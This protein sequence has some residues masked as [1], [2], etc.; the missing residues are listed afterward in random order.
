MYWVVWPGDEG[1]FIE[2]EEAGRLWPEIVIDFLEKNLK[3]EDS[4]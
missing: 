3:I 4:N 2:S 1:K